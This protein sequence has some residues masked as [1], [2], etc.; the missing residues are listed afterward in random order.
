MIELGQ[1]SL[2]CRGRRAGIG[3]FFSLIPTIDIVFECFDNA[4]CV[5]PP[6]SGF[7]WQI[8]FGHT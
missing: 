3:F 4:V 6:W 8:D 1:I 5:K 7:A 2:H